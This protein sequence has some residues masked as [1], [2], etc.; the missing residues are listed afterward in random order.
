[1]YIHFSLTSGLYIVQ[2]RILSNR[3]FRFPEANN[4]QYVNITQHDIF[5]FNF[6]FQIEKK[7][8][9]LIDISLV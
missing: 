5:F 7:L 4:L 3:Q 8:K 9:S 6:F 1:M 2:S